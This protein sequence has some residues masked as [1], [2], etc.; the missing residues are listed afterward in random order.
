[1]TED[2]GRYLRALAGWIALTLAAFVFW[3]WLLGYVMPFLLAV[4]LGAW[5]DPLVDWGERFHLPRGLSVLLGLAVLLAGL[6]ASLGLFVSVLMVEVARL[7][8]RLPN[9]F[10]VGRRVLDGALTWALGVADWRAPAATRLLNDH[11]GTLYQIVG[12]VLRAVGLA[13][14]ALPNVLLVAVLTVIA[15]FFL[16]RDKSVLVAMGD[17]LVPPAYRHRAPHLRGEVLR[18]TLGFVRA[19]MLVVLTT[20]AATAVGLWVYGSRYALLL[21]LLA[22][23]LDLVPFLGP[24]ALL[25]PWAVVELLAGR[26]W[27]GVGLLAVLAGVVLLRQ[28]V[29]PR[30][31]AHGTG[32]HPLTAL[33]ALYVGVRLFGAW[34][35]VIGPVSAMA[36]KAAAK[37]VGLPPFREA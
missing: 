3:R 35:F 20:A 36:L 26:A 32:L 6:A 7:A 31:V 15:A 27:S 37:T 10:A 21:G 12:A 17:W 11:L 30:L 2:N 24:T 14:V 34:G 19:Q 9:L 16:L 22:G 18:G 28:V 8:A 13:L 33:V 29:E 5:L 23:V 1:V 25:A 4:V